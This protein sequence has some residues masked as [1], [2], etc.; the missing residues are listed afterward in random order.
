MSERQAGTDEC[1]VCGGDSSNSLGR[2]CSTECVEIALEIPRRIG[3]QCDLCGYSSTDDDA[4]DDVADHLLELHEDDLTVEPCVLESVG[5][6][7]VHTLCSRVTVPREQQTLTTDGGTERLDASRVEKIL[8]AEF[9]D[10]IYAVEDDVVW[11]SGANAR[12]ASVARRMARELA[13]GHDIP[14]SPV[15]DDDA[16]RFG[17]V[18]FNWGSRQA[19]PGEADPQ[20]G[21]A[22]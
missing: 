6:A 18:Q 14:T 12:S 21:G 22:R 8:E 1:P 3:W 15:Y 13:Y 16:A 7:S 19:S 10:R 17:G 4:A 2:H 9:G 5:L 20:A 11:V